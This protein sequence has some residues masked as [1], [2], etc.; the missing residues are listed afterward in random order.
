[1]K[2]TLEIPAFETNCEEVHIL[3]LPVSTKVD[4][5]SM[6]NLKTL[7]F[8]SLESFP[9][10]AAY[11]FL[12]MTTKQMRNHFKN[13]EPALNIKSAAIS[14]LDD[15][16]PLDI[17]TLFPNLTHLSVSLGR[18]VGDFVLPQHQTFLKSLV[19]QFP[20]IATASL[21]RLH[22]L[23]FNLL[24]KSPDLQHFECEAHLMLNSPDHDVYPQVESLAF[25]RD[26]MISDEYWCTVVQNALKMFPNLREWKSLGML[27][28]LSFPSNSKWVRELKN[29]SV[30][31]LTIRDDSHDYEDLIFWSLADE[32]NKTSI[33]E[34]T[35]TTLNMVPTGIY[36]RIIEECA[37]L[38][39]ITLEEKLC[40]EP[41]V[42][43]AL[44]ISGFTRG[45]QSVI[46]QTN[47]ITFKK[48]KKFIARPPY[49][50]VVVSCDY[51]ISH[52]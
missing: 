30:T 16:H 50:D 23:I 51:T 33:T 18:E 3:D 49:S 37:K 39:K 19:V 36:V 2:E 46:D 25:N 24:K 11:P 5:R 34:F 20:R 21:Q 9:Y 28:M 10:N 32:L 15:S 31:S 13:A 44:A 43:N 22:P 8:Y 26:Y 48:P 38:T 6:S 7:R 4:L 47:Y 41:E 35:L 12:K 45:V 27:E 29:S 14:F 1:M 42:Q 17:F 40:G 52:F